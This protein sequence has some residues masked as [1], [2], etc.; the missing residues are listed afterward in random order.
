MFLIFVLFFILLVGIDFG[1]CVRVGC[2][3]SILYKELTIY[4]YY[5]YCTLLLRF[6]IIVS[7]RFLCILHKRKKKK[8][9]KRSMS[10]Y[11]Y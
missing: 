4:S 6:V 3:G 1:G 11:S 8:K 5:C 10:L 9:K 7:S 2:L